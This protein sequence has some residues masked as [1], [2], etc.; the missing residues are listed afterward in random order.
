VPYY[1]G[2]D[3]GGSKTTCT[4]GDANAV[5]ATATSGP[6]NIVRVGEARARES[7]HQAVR[8][9]C[10]AAGIGVQQVERVC[11]GASGAGREE[12]ANIVRKILA[13]VLQGHNNDSIHVLADTQIALAA[14][15]ASGPGVIVIAGTGS[16]AY[17]R[18]ASGETARAGGWGFAIS[19]E[20]S[21][22]WIG[23]A[24]LSAAL[25]TVD[26][27]YGA[28]ADDDPPLLLQL[29]QTWKLHSREDLIRAANFHGANA[30][31]APDFAAFFPVVLA[32]AEAGDALS[33][34]V[35]TAAAGE[36]A[37]LAL[38]VVR[39]LFPQPNSPVPMAMT[40]GVFRHAAMV[41]ELFYN[42]VRAAHPQVIVNP[43]VVEPVHGALQ[44]AREAAS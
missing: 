43:E 22:H 6:S 1:L 12:T 23:R 4:V 17:G 2:L 27:K 14:A 16:I 37:Q 36:L 19:D 15:F 35:L 28:Q 33:R 24:A 39:R 11:I 5:L 34:C 31:P 10:A 32:A 30:C 18:N 25:R 3:G 44:M 38:I 40:G 8:Q 20:G 42:D 7:L 13:E 29:M 9:A 21:A 41:R 26:Q